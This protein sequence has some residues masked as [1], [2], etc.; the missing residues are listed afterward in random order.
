[1]TAFLSI[2][3]H[4]FFFF[5][6]NPNLLRYYSVFKRFFIILATFASAATEANAQYD[7]SFSHYFDMEP[8]FNAAAVGKQPKLNITAA[9]AL[10][11][12]GFENNPNTMYAAADMPVRFIGALH[13]VGLQFMNDKI[14]LFS[15][16]RLALQY[17]YKQDRKSTRLNSSHP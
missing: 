13:G 9:Y 8:T 12:A 6:I 4:F 11:M 2:R 3:Q 16:Q 10:D 14:G 1:M 15:H 7:V 17:A 5:A